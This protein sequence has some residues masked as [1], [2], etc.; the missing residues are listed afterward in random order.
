MHP[1]TH[2]AAAALVGLGLIVGSL[3]QAPPASAD[4]PIVLKFAELKTASA[5]YYYAS[6]FLVGPYLRVVVTNAGTAAAGPFTVAV[7]SPASATLQSFAVPGLAA[8]QSTT[9]WHKLDQKFYCGVEFLT[10]DG[11]DRLIGVDTANAVVETN[12]TNNARWWDCALGPG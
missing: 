2:R 7:K 12:E 9:L 11:G 10:T 4:G 1:I 8:G 6:S 3:A 5:D